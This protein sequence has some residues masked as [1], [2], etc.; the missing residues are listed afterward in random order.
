MG[1]A[2]YMGFKTKHLKREEVKMADNVSFKVYLKDPS[3]GEETEVRRFV[4]DKEVSTSLVYI[5][6]KLVSIF[7]V[8]ADKIFS[9]SWT[10]ED[11]DSITIDTDEELI[12]ALTE[13]P[14]PVY[15]LTATVR[16]AKKVE[17]PQEPGVGANMTH[18]GVT[19]DGCDKA[20]I[21]GFRYKCVVCDDYDLCAACEKAGKHPGNNMMRINSP[22]VIWPQ[23]LFKR[24]HKMQEKAEQR[25]RCSLASL[26]EQHLVPQE[27]TRRLMLRRKP[28]PPMP[29]HLLTLL[30]KLLRQQRKLLLL[31][32]CLREVE[33]NT[34]RGLETLW[35]LRSTLLAST[36]RW[37]SRLQEGRGPLS[38]R[39]PRCSTFS[40]R[41]R[42][43]QRNVPGIP[44]GCF[45]VVLS[46]GNP[47]LIYLGSSIGR[48]ST[49]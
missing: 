3:Q 28:L 36:C 14:G 10:D 16:A 38:S 47:I 1:N 23:R 22:E 8:L 5:K 41:S 11:G 9:V 21:V 18:H 35:L 34:C 42:S 15:K 30:L 43:R 17:E 29:M 26:E 31:L 33:R 13:L 7:P 25:S 44:L 24:I 46:A 40:S 39:L 48:A 49:L 37:M 20:P 45:A 27:I 12:L 19:C 2:E 32:A 6:E 4:V